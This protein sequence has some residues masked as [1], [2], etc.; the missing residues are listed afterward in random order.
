MFGRKTNN[1][2][3]PPA[4]DTADLRMADPMAACFASSG[5]RIRTGINL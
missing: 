4:G 1:R 5:V 3:R 2:E